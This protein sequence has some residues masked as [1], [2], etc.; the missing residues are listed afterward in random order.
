[1]KLIKHSDAGIVHTLI[2]IQESAYAAIQKARNAKE[3]I[4]RTVVK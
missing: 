2:V 1:M 3:M 4:K